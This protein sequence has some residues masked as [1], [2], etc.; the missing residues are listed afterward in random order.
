MKRIA[1][2]L[3]SAVWVRGRTIVA[4][5]ARAPAMSLCLP[6]LKAALVKT[7][8]CEGGRIGRLA[9]ALDKGGCQRIN[10]DTGSSAEMD[11]FHEVVVGRNYPFELLP[12]TPSVVADCG[13]NIGY[14]ACLA[15]AAFPGARIFAWE[16]DK[17]N[18]KRLG[19]Q[20]LLGGDETTLANA[21]VSDHEGRVVLTG[22]GHGCEI[23]GEAAQ[24]EGVAC[25]DFGAW[26]REHAVPGTLLK[27]D[28]EGH[29]TAIL[30]ALKDGWKAPCAVFLETHATGGR[31]EETVGQ[32][33]DA[34]F[35]IE[36]LRSHSLPDDGRVFKEYC[37]I[38]HGERR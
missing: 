20:P 6:W 28:I 5:V 21:A 23:A 22:S 32:L 29:E 7:R 17:K 16:P 26:W 12:F 2:K 27:M 34:G 37:A 8:L 14:F 24:G 19:E 30:P 25:I 9:L 15:R 1:R 35:E 4:Y 3:Y 13:A 36:C 31:D 33:R 10:L 11:V 38:L 18:F